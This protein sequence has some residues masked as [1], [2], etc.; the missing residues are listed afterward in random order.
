MEEQKENSATET[1]IMPEVPVSKFSW[2]DFIGKNFLA[3][4]ILLTGVLISGSILYT[5]VAEVNPGTAQIL[6]DDQGNKRVDVSVDDDAVLGNKNAKVTIVEFSDYQCPF[7]RVFWRESYTQLKKE[8]ID[9]GK[10]KLV[11]RDYPLSFHPMGEPTAQAAECAEEQG[12]YWEFHDKV[13]TEQDKL[14]QATIT[15][16]VQDLKLWASQLG[17]NAV[18][19]NS[20]LDSGKYKAEVGNDI[21]DA[22]KYGVTGTPSFFINGKFIVGAQPYNTFKTLIEEELKK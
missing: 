5:K 2:L 11:F 19:F 21:A 17:L 3:L 18:A 22:T 14:G 6:Q 12:K 15:Y 4:S 10:V 20:C 7:C 1:V 9:T 13:F 16:T 8:Y